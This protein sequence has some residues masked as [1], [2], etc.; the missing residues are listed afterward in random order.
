MRYLFLLLLLSTFSTANTS[1]QRPAC[2]TSPTAFASLTAREEFRE[3][4][5]PPLPFNYTPREGSFKTFETLDGIKG[6]AYYIPSSRATNEVLLIFHE[7]WGLNDYVI[8][9]AQKYADSLGNV[10]IYAV[11]LY[12]GQLATTAERAGELMGGLKGER[13]DNIIKG[14]LSL[15]KDKRI[16]TI[17]WCMG[18]SYAFRASV[19]AGSTAA[20][21]VMYYGF[22]EKN[23]KAIAPLRTDVLYHRATRDGFIALKDVELLEK[24]VIENRRAFIR[25]DYDAVHAFAN[26]SNPDYNTEAALLAE[27]RTMAFLRKFLQVD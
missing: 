20:G 11:D 14:M 4:H 12:D 5:K 26:P 1:A 18:G 8:R 27:G 2:C 7:W 15:V 21:C 6:R 22:P 24:A 9:E 3:A 23:V 17:G 25:H 13:T 16:A 10:D 19:L